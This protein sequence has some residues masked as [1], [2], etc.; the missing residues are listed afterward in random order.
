MCSIFVLI[1]PR[2]SIG[3]CGRVPPERNRERRLG[4]GKLPMDLPCVRI[5]LVFHIFTHH[6]TF[7]ITS[8]LMNLFHMPFPQSWRFTHV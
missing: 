4:I 1:L 2:E 6:L 7:G 3:V 5:L 8:I